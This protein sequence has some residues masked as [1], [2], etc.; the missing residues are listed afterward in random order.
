M[1][2]G[3]RAIVE[4]HGEGAEL[5]AQLCSL[6]CNCADGSRVGKGP[7]GEVSPKNGGTKVPNAWTVVTTGI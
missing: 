4:E 7:G 3:K 6:Q 1:G 5:G 2:L